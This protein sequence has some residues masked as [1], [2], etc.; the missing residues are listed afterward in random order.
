MRQLEKFIEQAELVHHLQR[1]WMNGVAAEIAQ[2]V[3]VLFRHD[4]GNTSSRQQEAKHHPGGSAA[5]NATRCADRGHR[6]SLP[7]L[8]RTA[9]P[10]RFRARA[11]LRLLVRCAHHKPIELFGDFDLTRQPRIRANIIPEVEHVL[12]HWRWTADLLAPSLIDIDVASGAGTGAAAFS[13]NTRDIV[14]DRGFHDGR[15][16]FGFDRAART[17]GVC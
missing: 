1:R 8:L 5:N 17:A 12:F 4:D 10:A 14:A 6:H 15:A 9:G 7:G 16:E 2:E 13:L 11:A 3:S